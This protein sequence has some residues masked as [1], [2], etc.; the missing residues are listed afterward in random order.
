[1][2]KLWVGTYNRAMNALEDLHRQGEAEFQPYGD[3]QIVST[4]G[5]PQAEYAALHKSCALLDW[6]QRGV[7]E[8]TGKDRLEFLN[9]LLTNQT[10]D[11]A[12]KAGLQPGTGVYTFLLN[13][14]GR[15]EADLN[16]LELPDEGGRTWLEMDARLLEPV[17]AIL[18]RHMF[19]EKVTMESRAG[20]LHEIALY[21]P[22]SN[23]AVKEMT[24]TSVDDLPL[25][26]SRI[27]TLPEGPLVIWR[28]DPTGPRGYHLVG[29]I[30]LIRR[31]WQSLMEQFHTAPPGRRPLRPAGWAAWNSA[32]IEAGRPL[33]GVDFDSSILPAET[34]QLARAVSFTKG[35][36]LGQEIVARM[37]ARGQ[38]A[39]K[40]VGLRIDGGELPLAGV[41]IFDSQRNEVGGVTSSTPCPLLQHAAI[42][43]GYA[44]RG[45]F[46]PGTKLLIPAEGAMRQAEVVE[47]PFLPAAD[48]TAG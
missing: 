4:Y 6:P 29:S 48:K 38:V 22:T 11:K 44:K 36:Y 40:L 41:K 25:L 5:A 37:H 12:A 18:D 43:I 32:R 31:G 27:I 7:L 1:M 23:Q 13:T 33:F 46:D 9:N 14:K 35:C 2:P 21:G 42:A 3:V 16:V 30:A 8:L 26:G 19:G 20:Q 24:G 45:F 34:G 28:D 15:I 47:M 39:K 10:W 17:R